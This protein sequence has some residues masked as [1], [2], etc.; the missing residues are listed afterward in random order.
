MSEFN[1][2]VPTYV[3]LD[4]TV[5]VLLFFL[6]LNPAGIKLWLSSVSV[7]LPSVL[8]VEMAIFWL[9][10]WMQLVQ[11]KHVG[12]GRFL[13]NESLIHLIFHSVLKETIASAYS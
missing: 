12:A 10:Q 9:W 7:H 2:L 5:A 13:E 3:L 4:K 11:G 1:L 6:R 8:P